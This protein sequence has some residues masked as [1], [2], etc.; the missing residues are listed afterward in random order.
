MEMRKRQAST[1]VGKNAPFFPD[2]GLSPH[3][4]LI[5]S[6]YDSRFGVL[7]AQGKG[8]KKENPHVL[9]AVISN[10]SPYFGMRGAGVSLRPASIPVQNHQLPNFKALKLKV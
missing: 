2:K 1:I 5:S 7:E 9:G 10:S 3:F 4:R 8:E 6:S